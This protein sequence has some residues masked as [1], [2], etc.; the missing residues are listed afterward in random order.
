MTLLNLNEMLTVV[1]E[2][3]KVGL[4]PADVFRSTA[5]AP[6]DGE[7]IGMNFEPISDELVDGHAFSVVSATIN[8][9]LNCFKC[10]KNVTYPMDLSQSSP[11]LG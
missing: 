7:D 2:S 10:K 8:L 5:T 1:N 11:L 4:D 3:F 9:K 6:S